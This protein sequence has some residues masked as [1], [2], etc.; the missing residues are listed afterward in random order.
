MF[1][2]IY[3]SNN[4]KI[5][6]NAF[7]RCSSLS[8]VSLGNGLAILGFQVFYMY[9]PN[10]GQTSTVLASIVVP[11]TLTMIGEKLV[12]IF[13]HNNI[14]TIYSLHNRLYGN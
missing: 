4:Y 2:Y 14:K 8:L 9:D 6:D 3:N 10:T 1:W 7:L 11:S 13:F 12:Y 5:G